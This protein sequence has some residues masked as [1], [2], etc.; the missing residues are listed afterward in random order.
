METTSKGETEVKLLKPEQ[1]AEIRDRHE[2]TT[3]NVSRGLAYRLFGIA[4]KDRQALLDHI[5]AQKED[6]E[7]MTAFIDRYLAQPDQTKVWETIYSWKAENKALRK[8]ALHATGCFSVFDHEEDPHS[9]NCGL[10][11]LLKQEQE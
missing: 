1:L 10:D 6:L 5:T 3:T 11:E 2:S 8:Y 4:H 7:G 9:C